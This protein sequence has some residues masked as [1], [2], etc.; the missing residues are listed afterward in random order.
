MLGRLK[1]MKLYENDEYVKVPDS[2]RTQKT[3]DVINS[4]KCFDVLYM[5]KPWLENQESRIANAKHRISL[6]VALQQKLDLF[7]K[8]K[9]E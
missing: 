1:N 8:G 7:G 9:T 5:I 3:I 2:V 4:I 6:L